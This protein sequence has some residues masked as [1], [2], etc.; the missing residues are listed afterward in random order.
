VTRKGILVGLGVIVGEGLAVGEA[1]GVAEA[2]IVGITV[3][4]GPKMLVICGGSEHARTKMSITVMMSI[5]L[6][7]VNIYYAPSRLFRISMDAE[8]ATDQ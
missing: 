3:S 1:V 4:V 5:L 8:K 2:V 7:L 6:F